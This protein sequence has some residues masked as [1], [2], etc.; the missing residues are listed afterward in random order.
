MCAPSCHFLAAFGAGNIAPWKVPMSL[1]FKLLLFCLCIGLA[2]LAG[3]GAY[4]VHIASLGLREQAFHQLSAVRDAKRF[5]LHKQMEEWLRLT[6]ILA[7]SKEVY[8][9]LVQLRDLSLGAPAG[10]RIAPAEKH[11]KSLLDYQD[12]SFA[13]FVDSLGFPDAY[14]INDYGYILYSRRRGRDLGEDLLKGSLLSDSNL[15]KAFEAAIAGNTVIVDVEAYPALDGQPAAFLASP[16]HS[17]T[18]DIQG[19]AALRA[20]LEVLSEIIGQSEGIGQTART[21]LLGQ[22]SLHLS[23]IHLES[24]EPS[25]PRDTPASSDLHDPVQTALQGHSGVEILEGDEGRSVLAAYCPFTFDAFTWALVVEMDTAEAFA[26]ARQL[27]LAA[28]AAGLLTALLVIGVTLFFLRREFAKPLASIVGFLAQIAA[29]A[30]SANLEG[31][32]KAE[33]STLARGLTDMSTQI[34]KRLGFAQGVLAG[35]TFPCLFINTRN[36][37]THANQ[38]LL[39]LL[40]KASVPDAVLGLKAGEFFQ[41]NPDLAAAALLAQELQQV[42]HEELDL[43]PA[44]GGIRQVSMTST[45]VYDLDRRLLG[46]F[47]LYYDLT[48]IRRQERL[49]LEQNSR[50]HRVA[51]EAHEIAELLSRTSDLLARQVSHTSQ[52]SQVQ[53]RRTEETAVSIQ[54]I[55]ASLLETAKGVGALSENAD[56]ARLKVAEGEAA[57]RQ[58]VDAISRVDHQARELEST[59]EQLGGKARDIGRIIN[60]IEDIADQTNLLALNAA[61]EAARAGDAGRGFAVV[62]SEVRKL[63][64]KTMQATNEVAQAVAGIQEETGRSSLAVREASRSLHETTA[65][66]EKSGEALREIVKHVNSTAAG[67]QSIAMATQEQSAAVEL[68]NRTVEEISG[69]TGSTAEDMAAATS[70]IAG[71]AAQAQKLH[72]LIGDMRIEEER[73]QGSQTLGS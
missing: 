30:H 34:K 39:D 63:A 73:T 3:I 9:G 14:I 32:F 38:S 13:S 57:V 20:P 48:E 55:S 31:R 44:S 69:I 46:V 64:E 33:F 28:L 21:F 29:G 40:G 53:N 17:H 5:A 24:E 52:G 60:V 58:S 45:P 2:P 43:A 59:M 15:R 1:K 37:I 26:P 10:E 41:G 65:L 50:I 36:E 8:N 49:I 19:V 61:I 67:V 27:A 23:S 25:L 54:Q 72:A 51:R 22:N 62:A 71:L 6:R 56:R 66:A 7:A 4:S 42:I 16:I 11:F 70:S 12:E 18:G 35:V 68:I 47:S